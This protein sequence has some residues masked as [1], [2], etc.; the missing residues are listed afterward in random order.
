MTVALSSLELRRWTVEE[1]CQLGEQGFFRDE[2]VELIDGAILRMSPH[3]PPHSLAVG[4]LNNLLVRAFGDTHIVRVQLPLSV[5]T[6]SEPEPDFSLVRPDVLRA[7][8]RHP[9]SADL[10]IEVSDSSLSSDKGWKA[11]LYASAQVVEY[12]VLNIPQTRL[13]TYSQPHQDPEADFG[14]S[15][16]VQ[17]VYLMEQTVTPLALEGTLS[18]K[19][20]FDWP[21]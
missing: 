21:R 2:R 7:A 6:H 20:L 13:E 15:Y 19:D 11:S 14:W 9:T 5:G 17:R 18:I 8:K 4:F 16:L 3:N 12:W 10:V 1:Y